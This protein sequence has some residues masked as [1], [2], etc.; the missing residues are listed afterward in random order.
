M[1]LTVGLAPARAAGWPYWS[2]RSPLLYIRRPAR[3]RAAWLHTPWWGGEVSACTLPLTCPCTPMYIRLC[4]TLVY[5][6]VETLSV[7]ET[8][9]VTSRDS[10]E[11]SAPWEE[12]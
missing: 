3:A 10:G 9:T 8:H 2:R 4:Q 6:L 1:Q 5:E 12:L 7:G 11:N